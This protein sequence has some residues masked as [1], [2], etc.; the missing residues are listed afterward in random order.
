LLIISTI[1]TIVPVHSVSGAPF[2]RDYLS[3]NENDLVLSDGIWTLERIS[4]EYPNSLGS[5]S[6]DGRLKKA[7]LLNGPLVVGKDATLNVS[8][9]VLFFKSHTGN[10]DLF[11]ARILVLGRM[12]LTDSV[13]DSNDPNP[14]HPRPFIAALDGG[15]LDIRRSE[16]KHMGFALG[17][18]S[19]LASVNYYNTS[20]FEI[21]NSIFSNNYNGFYSDSSSDFLILNNVFHENTGY[22]INAHTG[23]HDF[24]IKSNKVTNNGKQGIMC[25]FRCE[26]VVITENLVT[27]NVEG[28]GLHWLTNS[29]VIKDNVVMNNEQFGIFIKT[30]SHSNS[31]GSNFLFNNGCH[32]GIFENSTN[33]SVFDNVIADALNNYRYCENVPIYT[34]T[35]SRNNLVWENYW[36]TG[37]ALTVAKH[38]P[39]RMLYNRYVSNDMAID[40]PDSWITVGESLNEMTFLPPKSR[41]H[42]SLGNFS[43]T[44]EN[45]ATN[46]T[47]DTFVREKVQTN[48][49]SGWSEVIRTKYMTLNSTAAQQV[50]YENDDKKLTEVYLV[51]DGKGYIMQ[52]GTYTK[53]FERHSLILDRMIASFVLTS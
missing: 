46:M 36:I 5:A 49:Q 44:T 20:D 16:I 2:I 52:F 6:A 15:K 51:S 13:L 41:S 19:S 53:I 12:E 45:V 47:L 7:Y 17:S 30:N 8:N 14:F 42:P 23:S 48:V 3:E 24:L 18:I 32:I 33:N 11:P 28:I 4:A 31:L 9:K 27:N 40:R 38:D 35:D 10:E 39:E 25:S 37:P 1:V 22:G 21:R 34:H 26:N 43:I 29:S 50:I